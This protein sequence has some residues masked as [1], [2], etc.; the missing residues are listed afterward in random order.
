MTGGADGAYF[1][2]GSTPQ[3]SPSRTPWS[4][5]ATPASASSWSPGGG[6]LTQMTAVDFQPYINI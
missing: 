1:G 4:S 3:T 5:G 2:G 6:M